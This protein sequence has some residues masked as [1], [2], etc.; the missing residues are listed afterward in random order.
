MNRRRFRIVPAPFEKTILIEAALEL[1]LIPSFFMLIT[2]ISGP[3]LRPF[4]LK[5]KSIVIKKSIEAAFELY[6]KGPKFNNGAILR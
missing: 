5:E 1:Y 4:I 2:T 3:S 6:P